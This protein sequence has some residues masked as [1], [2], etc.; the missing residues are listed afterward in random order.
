M[1]ASHLLT[2]LATTLFAFSSASPTTLHT[3]AEKA[4][5]VCADQFLA[6]T[7]MC[8][9]E[10]ADG[11][12]GLD[13]KEG[14]SRFVDITRRSGGMALLTYL[15]DGISYQDQ[16]RQGFQKGLQE[17]AGQLLC[18]CA[19]VGGVGLPEGCLRVGWEWE[20]VVFDGG[21]LVYG[22]RVGVSFFIS[23]FFFLFHFIFS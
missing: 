3:R 15:F 13:C 10:D 21:F 16:D 20:W 4:V 8:C 17:K 19:W 11:E 2:L 18:Y 1:H 14:Q 7:P 12:D 6:N 9:N 23:F 22:L 5:A